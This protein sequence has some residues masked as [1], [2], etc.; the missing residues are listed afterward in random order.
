A[1]TR[2]GRLEQHHA[3]RRLALHRVRDG[4]H[5]PR[6]PEEVLLGLF[7]ALGDRRGHLLGLSVADAD[8]A[9]TVAHHD[10]RGKAEPAPALDYLGDAVD[11]DHA[12]QVD[13]LLLGLATPPVVTPFPPLAAARP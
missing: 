10:E 8:H 2:A 12:L 3:G 7:D 5:D 11:R 6:H 1:G 4:A 9:V 13:R